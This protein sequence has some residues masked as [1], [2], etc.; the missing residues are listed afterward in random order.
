MHRQT[1]NN[2]FG[3]LML[4]TVII[5]IA[6]ATMSSLSLSLKQRQCVLVDNCFVYHSEASTVINASYMSQTI[7]H[8]SCH[9]VGCPIA[10]GTMM[11]APYHC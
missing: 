2:T 10:G 8:H 7:G 9:R 4:H 1:I 3:L 6:P 11:H 5:M